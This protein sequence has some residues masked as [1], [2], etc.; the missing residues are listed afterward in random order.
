[1][2]GETPIACSLSAEELLARLAELRAVGAD[3]LLG[4]DGPGALRFRNDE[5]T[6]RRLEAIVAAESECC[7]FLAFGLKAVGDE[8]ELRVTAPDGAEALAD[9]LVQAFAEGARA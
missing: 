8:L 1:M 6:R 9:D 4:A 5:A 7:G 2:T 3:A